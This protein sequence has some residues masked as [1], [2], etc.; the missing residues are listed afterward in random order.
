MNSFFVNEIMLPI[1]Q[2]FPVADTG[3]AGA[4]VFALKCLF[5]LDWAIVLCQ[6]TLL[7][8]FNAYYQTSLL[9]GSLYFNIVD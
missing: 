8:V 2:F 5:F 1:I 6:L 3:N 9:G 7:F 4:F